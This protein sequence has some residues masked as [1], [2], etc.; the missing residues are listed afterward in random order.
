[1]PDRNRTV[2]GLRAVLGRA[3]D[4]DNYVIIL[5]ECDREAVEDAISLLQSGAWVITLEEALK[6]AGPV[7]VD[8]RGGAGPI[9]AYLKDNGETINAMASLM[10]HCDLPREQY[11]ISWRCWNTHPTQKRK[12]EEPWKEVN[13]N[14]DH[15]D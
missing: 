5:R 15:A 8:I 10:W 12:E 7:Y 2:S 1:M 3:M 6:T 11:M 13:D 14:G 4:S 9:R